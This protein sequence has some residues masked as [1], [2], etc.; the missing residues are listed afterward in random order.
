MASG[1]LTVDAWRLMFSDS[2]R[3]GSV[4]FQKHAP[5]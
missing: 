4:K 2:E 5:A 3:H 1:S